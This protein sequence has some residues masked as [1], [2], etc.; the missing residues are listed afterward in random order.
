MNRV[1][2]TVRI[3][4]PHDV[5]LK[6]IAACSQPQPPMSM[7]DAAHCAVRVML[8]KWTPLWAKLSSQPMRANVRLPGRYGQRDHLLRGQG[9]LQQ[10]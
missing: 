2:V 6:H 9:L 7:R 1:K 10:R 4:M 5:M 8:I 3:P